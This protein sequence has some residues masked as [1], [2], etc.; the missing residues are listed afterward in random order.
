MTTS[1][2]RA[3]RSFCCRTIWK[4]KRYESFT[5]LHQRASFKRD[6]SYFLYAIDQRI[7]AHTE[8][9]LG[10]HESKSIKRESAKKTGIQ[11]AEKPDS[12]DI[13]FIL[14]NDYISFM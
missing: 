3:K 7:L 1:S 4:I 8:F 10:N 5:E 6:Q 13:C 2:S 9:P 14:N 11:V 12:Q